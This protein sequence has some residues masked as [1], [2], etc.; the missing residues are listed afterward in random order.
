MHHGQVHPGATMRSPHRQPGPSRRLELPSSQHQTSETAT[1]R[2]L[3]RSAASALVSRGAT[4]GGGTRPLPDR[5]REGSPARQARVATRQASTSPLRPRAE[6]LDR[7]RES[8]LCRPWLVIGLQGA[9]RRVRACRRG[10]NALLGLWC[11]PRV[12][13]LRTQLTSPC[14]ATDL[15]GRSPWAQKPRAFQS[16]GDAAEATLGRVSRERSPLALGHS[17]EPSTVVSDG[18]RPQAPRA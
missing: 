17:A 14:I 13:D 3:S 5:R 16:A 11:S 12:G 1:P 18:R 9:G 8:S 7:S 10:A 15:L 6:L 4:A 2:A